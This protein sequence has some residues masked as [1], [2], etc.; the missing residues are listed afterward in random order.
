M[1]DDERLIK[2]VLKRLW[3]PITVNGTTYDPKNRVPPMMPFE[4]L[5]KAHPMH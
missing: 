3:G 4:Q 1:G 2:V 5:L